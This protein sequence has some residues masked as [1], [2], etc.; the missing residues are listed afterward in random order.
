MK[1]IK[2][3]YEG[4][5][6]EIKRMLSSSYPSDRKIFIKNNDDPERYDFCLYCKTAH[7]DLTV[8]ITNCWKCYNWYHK[9]CA[10]KCMFCDVQPVLQLE[11][12][13]WVWTWATINFLFEFQ[14]FFLYKFIYFTHFHKEIKNYLLKG[15]S[16]L[17][18]I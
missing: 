3:L 5:D 6:H 2:K 7:E 9:H 1:E 8:P 14:Y 11:K 13:P 12:K 10:N 17:M 16:F 15:V 4:V 18:N